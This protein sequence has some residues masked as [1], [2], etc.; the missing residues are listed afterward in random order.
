MES[1]DSIGTS[2]A[3]TPKLD[4]DLHGAPM[5]QRKYHS[6]VGFLMYPTAS[7]PDMLYVVCLC[8][9]SLARPIE[10]HL[11]EV[12]SIRV[13]EILVE[14]NSEQSQHDDS[15]DVLVKIEGVEE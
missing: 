10:K 4:V 1:C 12:A 6:L 11:K 8:A 3:T 15:E 5:D 14:S 2:T 9:R 7:R 13:R